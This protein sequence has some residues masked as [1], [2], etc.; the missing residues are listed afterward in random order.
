MWHLVTAS[1]LLQYAR[2]L[3]YLIDIL[4]AKKC[5]EVEILQP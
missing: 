3:I 5:K 4:F 1:N 2:F